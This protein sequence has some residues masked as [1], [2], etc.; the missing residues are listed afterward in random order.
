MKISKL[1]LLVSSAFLL[2]SC[3]EKESS[4]NT[5]TGSRE[6]SSESSGGGNI[7]YNPLSEY[8][9]DVKSGM[10]DLF[11]ELIPFAPFDS[12]TFYCQAEEDEEYG[13][14]EMYIGDD[15]DNNIFSG[16]A[17]QLTS[18]GYA[19]QTYEG[20]V[21]YSKTVTS[22]L[23]IE[24]SFDWYAASSDYNAGNEIYIFWWTSAE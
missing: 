20:E 10:M 2:A 13:Y 17:A 11:G 18:N 22:G 24:L 9:A 19:E 3:G 21:Y 15:N 14:V 12:E 23:E 1:L 5:D 4:A 16:Y 6:S 8:P 7:P